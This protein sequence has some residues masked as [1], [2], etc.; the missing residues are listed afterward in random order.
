MVG[1]HNP[2]HNMAYYVRIQARDFYSPMVLFR[3]G[4]GNECFLDKL[5]PKYWDEM[6]YEKENFTNS[7]ARDTS[8]PRLPSGNALLPNA[9]IPESGGK[10]IDSVI[11]FVKKSARYYEEKILES[12]LGGA[13]PDSMFEEALLRDLKFS[14]KTFCEGFIKRVKNK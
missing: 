12:R 13:L 1:M 11:P 2:N 7:S 5:N 3:R 4:I 9:G 14:E 6:I 8:F 10:V